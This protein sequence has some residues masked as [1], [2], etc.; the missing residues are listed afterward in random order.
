MNEKSA[1]SF[2]KYFFEYTILGL[3]SAVIYLFFLYNSLTSKLFEIQ[4]NVIQKNTEVLNQFNQ[5][6]L[7][8]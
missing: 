1:S 5:S 8:R 2:R 4:S 7:K 6:N 3:V